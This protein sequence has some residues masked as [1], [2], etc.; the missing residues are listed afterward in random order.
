VA[1]LALSDARMLQVI[2]RESLALPAG[3]PAYLSL[4]PL[5]S[6]DDVCGGLVG[7]QQALVLDP[8]V[9]LDEDAELRPGEVDPGY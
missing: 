4:A 2:P 1:Q 7:S 8:A 5:L 6:Q 9:E 3:E